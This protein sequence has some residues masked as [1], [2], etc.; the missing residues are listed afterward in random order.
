MS[1]T[2][3][4]GK[5]LNP[6]PGAKGSRP[7]KGPVVDA[8]FAATWNDLD[9]P[10]RRQIRRL[11]RAGRPQET[12]QDAEL[13]SAF[14]AYQRA[15]P[16]YRFF[17]LWLAPLFVAGVIAGLAIHPIIVGMVLAASGNALIVHRNF[18]RVDKVNASLSDA[19][20]APAAA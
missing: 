19:S 17:W 12:E 10:T 6:A 9:K 8:E 16:W 4:T 1:R 18:K 15:R 3:T 7:K 13:A 14:A 2:P 11:V 5:L 20:V